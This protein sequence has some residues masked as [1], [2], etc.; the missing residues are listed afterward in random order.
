VTPAPRETKPQDPFY[1]TAVNPQKMGDN[2][3]KFFNTVTTDPSQASAVT[4]G[5]LHDQGAKGL[6][7]R[8]SD[9]AY[10]EVKK[11]TI[12]PDSNAT[13]NTLEVTHTDGS[14]T[15]EQRTL[16]FGDDDKITDDGS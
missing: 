11:V 1:S 9:V 14:K 3:E 13:V 15:T 8:Y 6:R 7:Q 5:Q 2:S 12:D 10:F 16:T 4:T